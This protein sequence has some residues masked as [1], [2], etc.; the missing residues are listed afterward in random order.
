MPHYD[1]RLKLR[2]ALAV[3]F[4]ANNFGE[5]GGYNDKWVT[6]K[7]GPMPFAFPNTKA[8]RRAVRLH[9]LHHLITGYDTDAV[10]EGEISA[11]EVAGSCSDH[12]AAWFL[13]LNAMC[14]ATLFD[15]R[16]I[17]LAFLR[18]R[19]SRNYYS[20]GIEDLLMETS[21]G[22]ARR[23]LLAPETSFVATTVDRMVFAGWW[24]L[25]LLLVVA[26]LALL[27]APFVWLGSFL[28]S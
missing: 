23:E 17:W 5:D 20:R 9:D 13:N 6:G 10:G 21:L 26:Q 19:H 1:D 11:W 18:G 24:T 12:W 14:V 2:E 7:F 16:A 28:L 4:E 8:R 3:Y 27:T 22:A 15:R 25:G